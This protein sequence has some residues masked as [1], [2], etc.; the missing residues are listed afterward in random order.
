MKYCL[1][2]TSNFIFWP[3]CL[4]SKSRFLRVGFNLCSTNSSI[5]SVTKCTS[6]YTRHSFPRLRQAARA[7]V[8]HHVRT[9]YRERP[10]HWN[11]SSHGAA[12]WVTPEHR[13]GRTAGDASS[14]G[15]SHRR[16]SPHRP[17][18]YLEEPDRALTDGRTQGQL[19]V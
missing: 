15:C 18:P 14:G 16:V 3:K 4:P 13:T 1:R 2:F 10:Q 12:S 6:L 19:W 9:R 7:A 5:S 17:T 8:P 11:G